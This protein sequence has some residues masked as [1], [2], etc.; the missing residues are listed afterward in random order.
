MALRIRCYTAVVAVAAAILGAEACPYLGYMP[1]SD[2]QNP[3]IAGD[4]ESSNKSQEAG[5][6]GIKT[7]HGRALQEDER[8]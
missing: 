8:F 5:C 6:N 4:A 3:H 7:R 1:G 2:V